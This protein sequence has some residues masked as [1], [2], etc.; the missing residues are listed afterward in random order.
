VVYTLLKLMEVGRSNN[1]QSSRAQS[2]VACIHQNI[3]DSNLEHFIAKFPLYLDLMFITNIT[4]V[5]VV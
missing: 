4:V 2:T 1:F 5:L 3:M